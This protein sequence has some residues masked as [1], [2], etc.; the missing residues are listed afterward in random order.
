MSDFD[1][2]DDVDDETLYANGILFGPPK[3]GKTTGAHTAPGRVLYLNFDLKNATLYARSL[4]ENKGRVRE[5]KVP[6]YA[7]DEQGN[8][9][10]QIWGM[11]TKTVYDAYEGKWDTIVV[12]P[13]GE[14]HRRLLEEQTNKTRRPSLDQRGNVL[15]DIE[16][17]CRSLSEAPVNFVVVM[18]EMQAD[19]GEETV[20]IPFT[21]TQKSSQGSLGPKLTGM[22]DFIAYTGSVEVEGEGQRWVAQLRPGRGPDGTDRKAGSRFAPLMSEAY[23]EVNLA[24]W[25]TEVGA[26]TGQAEPAEP[27]QST[28]REEVAA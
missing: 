11:M 27:E 19:R 25:F 22:V 1:F 28:T 4:P 24:E 7:A 2:R 16:R 8:S 6:R 21:G 15:T 17:W 13:L 9:L 3:T 26:H 18:H 12:D 14:L 10:P 20:A 5:P 23:R